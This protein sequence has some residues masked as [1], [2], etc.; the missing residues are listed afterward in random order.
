[1]RDK[2]TSRQ[3]FMQDIQEPIGFYL[4]LN[5][6]NEDEAVGWQGQS[7]VSG[8]QDLLVLANSL[9]SGQGPS[10]LSTTG[11]CHS[12]WKVGFVTGQKG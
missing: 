2:V 3:N 5:P 4:E 10:H 6:E 12:V 7:M 11:T 1:M 9:C 8:V